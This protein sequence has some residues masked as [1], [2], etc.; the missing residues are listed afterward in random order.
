M[1]SRF[2]GFLPAN[3]VLRN[4]KI[5]K[6]LNVCDRGL[7]LFPDKYHKPKEGEIVMTAH[8]KA[9]IMRVLLY[10]DIIDE[11][12]QG[13]ASDEEI[14]RFDTRIEHFLRRKNRYFECELLYLDRGVV[15][16]DWSEYLAVTRKAKSR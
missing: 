6:R 10:P 16:L 9:R 14:R 5:T 7:P 3:S 4:P 12:R 15:R 1:L 13:G 11:M 8:G 2:T